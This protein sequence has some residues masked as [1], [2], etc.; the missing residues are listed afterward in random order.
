M[1]KSLQICA[2]A[3]HQ[4]PWEF[5]NQGILHED[6]TFQVKEWCK[7][8]QDFRPIPTVRILFLVNT[9]GFF[10]TSFLMISVDLQR[11]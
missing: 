5:F 8:N 3:H 9:S 2:S 10:I 11:Q 4:S 6:V 1:A 7:F